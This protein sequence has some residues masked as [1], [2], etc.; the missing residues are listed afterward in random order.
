MAFQA[1]AKIESRAPSWDSL[2]ELDWASRDMRKRQKR[3]D[4]VTR[5]LSMKLGRAPTEQELAKG[6]GVK[7]ERWRR[8]L[9]EMRSVGLVSTTV[10]TA[11]DHDRTQEFPDA[12]EGQLDRVCARRQL[13][14]TPVQAIGVLTD[15]YQ[16]AV[17]LYYTNEMTMKEI[18]EILGRQR[19]PSRRSTKRH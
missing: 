19:E 2:R 3:T 16:K 4:G 13:R 9:G 15:R 5:D 7:V 18:G 11:G 6:M 8:M 17:S 1:Y 10:Q 14:K 12:P